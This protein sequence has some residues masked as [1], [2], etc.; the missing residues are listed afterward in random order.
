MALLLAITYV[1][2]VQMGHAS[3]FWTF[4]FQELFNDIRNSLI[5]WVLTLAIIL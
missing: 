1:S 5:Q 3:P 2:S 4:T